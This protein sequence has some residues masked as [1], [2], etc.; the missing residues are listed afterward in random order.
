MSKSGRKERTVKWGDWAELSKL[1]GFKRKNTTKKSDDSRKKSK[2][3]K[4]TKC[5]ECGG[6]MTYVPDS[7]IF[8]CDNEVEKKKK[9]K[10]EDGTIQEFTVTERCGN[11]NLIDKQYEGYVKWLFN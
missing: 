11:V 4:F 7:N 3:E 8:V 6:Q 10:L 2:R 1:T 9:K 5:K